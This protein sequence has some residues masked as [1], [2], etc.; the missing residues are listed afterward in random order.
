MGRVV[1]ASWTPL[2]GAGEAL[3]ASP[4][5]TEPRFREQALQAS[6]VGLGAGPSAALCSVALGPVLGE[7]SAVWSWCLLKNGAPGACAQTRWRSLLLSGLQ[8]CH[9]TCLP[10]RVASWGGPTRSPPVAHPCQG[11]SF[12]VPSRRDRVRCPMKCVLCLLGD[13]PLAG[14]FLK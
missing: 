11:D 10:G 2:C 9:C 14:P 6:G 4:V 3:E 8:N 7:P 13:L 1:Q 5:R 12:V